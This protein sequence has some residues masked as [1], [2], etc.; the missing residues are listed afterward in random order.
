MKQTNVECRNVVRFSFFQAECTLRPIWEFCCYLSIHPVQTLVQQYSK[1]F[2]LEVF[3]FSAISVFFSKLFPA[4]THYQNFI[5]AA[6]TFFFARL[7]RPNNQKHT[8]ENYQHTCRILG[9]CNC[10]TRF[11]QDYLICFVIKIVVV[12]NI[13]CKTEVG[14][15]LICS[16]GR[17]LIISFA[18]IICVL[19]SKDFVFL[20]CSRSRSPPTL[21]IRPCLTT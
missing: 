10:F 11:I 13:H 4:A 6:Y 2:K 3:N 14:K 17:L 12:N 9:S 21:E 7:L 5:S 8:N 1:S 15:T 19:E 18:R 20:I 16:V